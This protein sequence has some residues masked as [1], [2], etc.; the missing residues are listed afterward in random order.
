MSPARTLPVPL[1]VACVLVLVLTSCTSPRTPAPATSPVAA[2][3][4]EQAA[5]RP[6]SAPA[7]ATRPPARVESPAR[8]DTLTRAPLDPAAAAVV[9][10]LATQLLLAPEGVV[11]TSV[12]TAEWPDGCLGLPAEGENCSMALTP[13][14][15]ITARVGSDT[16]DFRT[17]L[18]GNRVRLASAPPART[19]DPLVTWQDSRSF[20]MMIVGTQRVAIGRRGRP[21]IASPLAVPTR[22][23]EL[24]GFLAHFSPFQ[25]RTEAG[26]IALRGVGGAR[27]SATEQRMIA[28]WARLV[29]LEA[30]AG[31]QE[32][33]AALALRWIQ[34]RG[35]LCDVVEVSRT[36]AASAR[37]CREGSAVPIAAVVL[38]A[39]E[40]E[41]LYGWLDR[42]EAFELSTE[43]EAATGAD[44]GTSQLSFRGTGF[45]EPAPA[46]H[47]AVLAWVEAVAQRLRDK[48]LSQ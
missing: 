22:A 43:A 23:T 10:R 47:E 12:T 45:D 11:V 42:L 18:T 20:T 4:R 39:T 24:Q 7:V 5:P 15:A 40:L 25:A 34:Q 26:D 14:Y 17:D 16:Y 30:R 38:D 13:G 33:E 32:P 44:S 8:V 48:A 21:M 27:A 36:G 19:G 46:D 6:R 41:A 2:G 3:P 29:S 35:D 9:E 31:A 37:S 28:E 1:S